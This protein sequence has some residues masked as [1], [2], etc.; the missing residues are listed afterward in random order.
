MRTA[1]SISAGLFHLDDFFSLFARN[2]ADLVS[3]RTRRSLLDLGGFLNQNRGRRSLHD[4][5]EALIGIGGNHNRNRKTRFHA[6][7]LSVKRLAEFHD[8][9]AALTEGRSDGRSRIG[10]TSRNLQLDKADNLLCHFLSPWVQSLR[11]HCRSSPIEVEGAKLCPT[12]AIYST[13]GGHNT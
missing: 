1:A 12:R 11:H 4:E 3:L 9:Q 2:L 6:L 10:F 5:R 7:R 8:V 13:Q